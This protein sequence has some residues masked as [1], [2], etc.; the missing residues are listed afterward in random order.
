MTGCDHRFAGRYLR[1]S[2]PGRF[3]CWKWVDETVWN[4]PMVV[5]VRRDL[6]GR[7]NLKSVQIIICVRLKQLRFV[8]RFTS[9]PNLTSHVDFINIRRFLFHIRFITQVRCG[10]INSMTAAWRWSGE[11]TPT[12]WLRIS[13]CIGVI[14]SRRIIK[15]SYS[16]D[17][18]LLSSPWGL[19]F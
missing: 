6:I 2:R 9:V 18:V 10:S 5:L 14:T 1:Q 3:N 11:R 17:S 13:P 15:S 19:Q 4:L 7:S 16:L 12:P 8:P